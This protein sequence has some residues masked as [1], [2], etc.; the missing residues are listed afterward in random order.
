MAT[1]VK[2]EPEEE[3]R[4]S[5]S[6]GGVPIQEPEEKSEIGESMESDEIDDYPV[7]RDCQNHPTN[8]G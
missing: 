8:D 6:G 7:L 5:T 2:V 4:P 1:K 3:V